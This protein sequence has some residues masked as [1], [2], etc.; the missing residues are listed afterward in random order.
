MKPNVQ[1]LMAAF[2]RFYQRNTRAMHISPGKMVDAFAES[3]DLLRHD[4]RDLGV[5]DLFDW[6][7]E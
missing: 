2:S 1:V 4:L 7:E 3:R 6:T 5:E